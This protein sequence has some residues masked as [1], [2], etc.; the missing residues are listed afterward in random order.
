MNEVLNMQ[1]TG[2]GDNPAVCLS[3][4]EQMAK[5][6]QLPLQEAQL[7][8][9][10]KMVKLFPPNLEGDPYAFH[11]EFENFVSHAVVMMLN[12]EAWI[13]PLNFRQKF[14]SAFPLINKSYRLLLT[15]PVTVAKD[16]RSFNRLKLIKTYLHT[17]MNNE[18]LKLFCCSLAR[19]I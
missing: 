18:R 4:V 13:M 5:V 12:S 16:E 8:D 11:A 15:A 7:G 10:V 1:I 17:A 9:V 3:I 19:R 2:L 6:L 14:K